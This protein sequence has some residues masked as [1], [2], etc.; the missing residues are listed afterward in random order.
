MVRNVASLQRRTCARPQAR[1]SGA[2][3]EEGAQ[4]PD[5]TGRP[6]EKEVR[7]IACRYHTGERCDLEAGMA[8]RVFGGHSCS[9][10]FDVERYHRDSPLMCIGEGT[11]EMQRIIIARQLVQ[12]HPA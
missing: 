9:V 10:Y 1:R 12:R 11:N 4:V 8:M 6:V 5:S 3:P 2:S 7:P